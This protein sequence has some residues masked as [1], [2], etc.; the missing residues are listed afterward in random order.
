MAQFSNR[1]PRKKIIV[2]AL[3]RNCSPLSLIIQ[4]HTNTRT[5]KCGKHLKHA[6]LRSRVYV[7]ALI[8]GRSHQRAYPN[9]HQ[10][11]VSVS[12]CLCRALCRRWSTCLRSIYGV[13]LP[14]C[15]RTVVWCKIVDRHVRRVDRFHMRTHTHSLSHANMHGALA[16]NRHRCRHCAQRPQLRR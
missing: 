11:V 7:C 13:E 1:P 3:L 6:F 4:T 5:T 9:Q 16:E 8:S 2:I 10:T 12:L 14:T 15:A